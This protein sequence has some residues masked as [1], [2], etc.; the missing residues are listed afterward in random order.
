M[1]LCCYKWKLCNHHKGWH[2][3]PCSFL[4][5]CR[6]THPCLPLSHWD[7]AWK[8]PKWICD[9]CEVSQSPDT[10]AIH[11][12]LNVHCGT[13]DQRTKKDKKKKKKICTLLFSCLNINHLDCDLSCCNVSFILHAS[14][15]Y[16]IFHCHI[17]FGMRLMYSFKFIFR[18]NG[19][20]NGPAEFAWDHTGWLFKCKNCYWYIPHETVVLIV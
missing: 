5:N 14:V 4:W 15:F 1:W 2:V 11:K 6:F 12:C 18:Y 13:F 9:S 8:Q 7:L 17:S 10:G 16:C 3:N 19:T 20:R